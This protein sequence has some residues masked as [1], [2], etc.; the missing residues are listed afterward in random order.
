MAWSLLKRDEISMYLLFWNSLF[1]VLCMP[2]LSL[3]LVQAV[4]P[5]WV[6]GYKSNPFPPLVDIESIPY[7]FF[8]QASLLAIVSNG[9]DSYDYAVFCPLGFANTICFFTNSGATIT[10]KGYILS[11]SLS[12]LIL[13]LSFWCLWSHYFALLAA[14]ELQHYSL[15]ELPRKLRLFEEVTVGT[16]LRE[17]KNLIFVLKFLDISMFL[18]LT[19]LLFCWEAG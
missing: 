19:P 15:P 13:F 3:S 6:G 1:C 11:L 16:H 17:S 12:L 5:W 2:P 4:L 18:N 9:A 7:K 14:N 10:W 8:M